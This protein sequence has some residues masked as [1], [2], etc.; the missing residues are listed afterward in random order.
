LRCYKL[1]RGEET[2]ARAVSLWALIDTDTH[3]LVRVNDFELGL[4]T[5]DPL[6]LPI[7]RFIIPISVK[8]VGKYPVHY[9]DVDQNRHMNNTRYPDM[10]AN[11]LPMENMRISEITLNYQNEAPSGDVLTVYMGAIGDVYYFRTVRS[12]G[13][14]NTE[15]EVKLVRI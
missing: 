4:D 5:F 15:A 8:E 6:D 11:Y 13:K 3:S 9:G 14:I 7:G 2:V 10:Y 1:K 12:D